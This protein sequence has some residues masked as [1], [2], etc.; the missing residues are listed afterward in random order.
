MSDSSGI[1]VFKRGNKH[2]SNSYRKIS[3]TIWTCKIYSRTITTRLTKIKDS[4]LL[5]EQTRLH[6]ELS[7]I[8]NIFTMQEIMKNRTVIRQT[9]LLFTDYVK[10]FDMVYRSKL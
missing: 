2:N 8:D 10:S 6:K 3:L 5:K 4:L 7:G 9:Y 1:P